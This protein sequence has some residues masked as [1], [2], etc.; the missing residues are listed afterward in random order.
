[1]KDG[2]W[3][4][5]LLNYFSVEG[6]EEK[7]IFWYKT[8]SLLEHLSPLFAAKYYLSLIISHKPSIPH[9]RGPC[10]FVACLTEITLVCQNPVIYYW[11]TPASA[12]GLSYLSKLSQT[13]L[14]VS[15]SQLLFQ[16]SVNFPAPTEDCIGNLLHNTVGLQPCK[17][18]V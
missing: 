5:Q 12:E 15:W 18:T 4:K 11:M 7:G 6:N 9:S 13:S 14:R 3:P 8:E 17:F 2:Y 1:M 10:C 16:S